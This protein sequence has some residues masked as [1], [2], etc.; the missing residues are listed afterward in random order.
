MK[1]LEGW[2]VCLAGPRFG[3]R[4][5]KRKF[6]HRG[7]AILQI[8]PITQVS[9]CGQI[10]IYFGDISLAKKHSISVL[11]RIAVGIQEWIIRGSRVGHT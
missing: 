10:L 9:N 6:Y 8:L 11:I 1:N 3:Y 7:R 5:F 2:D 4:D